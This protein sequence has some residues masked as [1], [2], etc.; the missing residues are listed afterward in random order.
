MGAWRTSRVRQVIESWFRLI[1][2]ALIAAG[3]TVTSREVRAVAGG[4]AFFFMIGLLPLLGLGVFLFDAILPE[5]DANHLL[6]DGLGVLPSPYRAAAEAQLEARQATSGSGWHLL[7]GGLAGLWGA[8]TGT[9]VLIEGLHVACRVTERPGLL[10]YQA[11]ALVVAIIAVFASGVIY[12]IAHA[13]DGII[14]RIPGLS[15]LGRMWLDALNLTFGA[16]AIA[17]VYHIVLNRRTASGRACL[18]GA[19][20]ATLLWLLAGRAL[21]GYFALG[22]FSDVYGV[23]T[24]SM[25]FLLWLYVSSTAI[26]FGG[27]LAAEFTKAVRNE[28]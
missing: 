25:F 28:N 11:L 5:E 4:I 21:S 26:L 16:A 24:G 3:R 19:G 6:A 13:I 8:I 2:G 20:T 22:S 10:V 14:V 18:I 27:A 7:A 15:A 9:K 12:P 17:L 23:L 1:F